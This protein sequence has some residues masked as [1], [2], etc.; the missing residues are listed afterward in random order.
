MR[1]RRREIGKFANEPY[2]GRDEFL[3]ECDPDMAKEVGEAMGAS[4]TY[5]GKELAKWY[6]ANIDAYSGGNVVEVELDFNGG[7]SVGTSYYDCH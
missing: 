6:K 3:V 1:N 4:Y 2:N 7:Y 5:A